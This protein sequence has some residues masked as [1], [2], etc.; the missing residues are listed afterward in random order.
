MMGSTASVQVCV[1]AGRESGGST[2]FRFRWRLLHALGPVLVAAF[3][4]SPLRAGRATGWKSTRQSVWA[5][6]DPGRTR[7]GLARSPRP[8]GPAV[9]PMNSI[10]GPSGPATHSMRK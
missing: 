2:G 10:R 7:A 6:L 1:D 3:A 9:I 4:N 8:A 5:R